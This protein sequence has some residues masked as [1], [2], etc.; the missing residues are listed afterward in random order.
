MAQTPTSTQRDELK[1]L[2]L[3]RRAEQQTEMLQ[4]QKNLSPP[5][6][7]EGGMVQRNVA[8]EVD[9][10]LTDMEPATSR[11]STARSRPWQTAATANATNVAAT[12][13]SSG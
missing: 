11:E 2:P 8:R 4:N 10:V 7:D 5:T 13:P 6:H 3:K 9:Q 1:A 12:F